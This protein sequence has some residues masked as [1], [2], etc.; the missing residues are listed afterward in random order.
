MAEKQQLVHAKYLQQVCAQ[1][2]RQCEA[3]RKVIAL[4]SEMLALQRKKYSSYLSPHSDKSQ[5]DT[6]QHLECRPR[7]EN[8]P[9]VLKSK[10]MDT[11]PVM[12]EFEALLDYFRQKHGFDFTGYKRPSLMRR[13][14]HRMQMI[15]IHSYCNYLDYLQVHPQEFVHLFSTILINF[16][17]FFRDASAWDYVAAQIVPQ[18]VAGK[19]ESE[20]IRV[21]SAG[22]ASGEET[23]TLAM[24]LAEAQG[25]EQYNARVQIF[26]TDVDEEALNFARKG[27]YLSSQV[28]GIPP[29]LLERYFEQA[30]DRYIIRQDLRRKIIF[31]RHN[32]IQD[33]PISK[34]DLL[35]CRNVLIYFN[36]EAQIRT[37]ARFHF[38][39]K[40]SGFLFLGS[41]EMMSTHTNFV[42]SVNKTHHVFNK[43]LR[44]D[45]NRCL[46]HE[47]LIHQP[48]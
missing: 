30:D 24:I 34:I 44:G 4:T 45:V 6:K 31:C 42:T 11:T 41:A 21:W 2:R 23:Y 19:S 8:Q 40:D 5:L 15:Q 36:K 1:V 7:G 48:L 28:V 3:P 25:V 46:L 14:Q 33:A 32:L 18:I 20:P 17:S 37:L 13:V 29:T 16:T 47:A 35:V 9:G 22:C 26:S 27:S 43:V 10:W 12:P 39:L 38:G